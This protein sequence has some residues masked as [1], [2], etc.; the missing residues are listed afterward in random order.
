MKK[1]SNYEST[2]TFKERPKLPVGA[3]IAVIKAAEVREYKGQN[4][5]YE[6]FEV[7]FDIT[8]GEYKDFYANDFKAQQSEDKKWKGV[9]RFYVPT[10]DGSERDSWT[11]STFKAN[12][13]AIEDS[14]SGYSWDWDEKKLKGKKVGVLFRNEEWEFNGNTGWSARPFKLISV[15]SVKDGKF[16]LPKD[17]PLANKTTTSSP[18][19]N[20]DIEYIDDDDLPF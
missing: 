11:K 20:L 13:E 8:E 6:K 5:T 7:A 18:P 9:V 15:D 19:Q 16:K 10:D 14:N 4:G 17:K 2:E 12:I 3:Y 1:F